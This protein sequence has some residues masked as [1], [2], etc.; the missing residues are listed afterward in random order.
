MAELYN[1]RLHYWALL[2]AAVAVG[3]I[4]VGATVTSTGS[5]DAVP[6]WPL[7]YG[8]LTPP[9]IGG[10]LYEHSHRL[11]AGLTALLVVV[12]AVWLWRAESRRYVRLLG[13]AAVG[14]VLLQATLGGLRVLI[15]STEAVQDTAIQL[16]GGT[17]VETTRI[18]IAITHGTL[19]QSILGVLFAIALF[20]SRRWMNF[21][22]AEVTERP[23]PAVRG[24]SVL[25]VGLV[26]FQLVLGAVVRH[27]GAS[28]IIP[29]FPTAFGRLIPPFG[30]LPHDPNAPFPLTEAELTAKTAVHF[31]HRVM[32]LLILIT[33]TV[34]FFRFRSHFRVGG[35]T[36]I[37][38][39]LVAVQILLGGLNIWTRKAVPVTVLHVV[40][41][42][43][44]LA[45]S[46]MLM[47]WAWRLC[48]R[49]LPSGSTESDTSLLTQPSGG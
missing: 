14:A 46:V 34:M 33:A 17:H 29:D 47:L 21:N 43:L 38:L 1:R 25:L 36:R 35:F 7:S 3:L 42:A 9:M 15:V 39:G 5:G 23:E 20:T 28:L 10:I 4:V 24:W 37:V 8:S 32:A 26:F 13:L 11:V 40:V 30:N 18:A 45:S 27:T 22:P 44:I 41:G 12:L 49:S 19:A 48:G 6:D 2:T 31:A 16:T